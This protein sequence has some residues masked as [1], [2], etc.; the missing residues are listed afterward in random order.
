MWKEL[1]EDAR[2][3]HRL[4]FDGRARFAKWLVL[5]C[6]SPGFV[7]LMFQRLNARY[8][9]LRRA[10]G[11]T[12]KTICM[13]L[14]SE[15][16]RWLVTF[17]AKAEV[18]GSVRIEPGVYLSNRGNLVIGAQCIGAGTIIH[19][20]VTIGMSLLSRGTP[21]IGANVWVGPDCVIYGNIDVGAGATVLPGTVLTK[22]IPPGAVVRGNP[23]RVVRFGFDNSALRSSLSWD[24][25]VPAA[26][27]T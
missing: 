5:W 6:A 4:R 10:S 23:A 15:L 18:L 14:L 2:L 1:Q 25:D 21:S 17:L 24:V 22:S 13:R 16:G 12:L 9:E 11:W 27:A 3:Y 8:S 19:H 20:R 7:T 26:P